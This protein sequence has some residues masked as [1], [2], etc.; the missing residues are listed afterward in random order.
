M[1][2]AD[3]RLC[4][5]CGQ[6]TFYDSELD[7]RF[8]PEANIGKDGRHMPDRCGDWAVICKPCAAEWKCGVVKKEPDD[9]PG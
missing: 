6:K 5:V 8:G 4:D 7:Y 1:A 3:Y 9:G 2:A